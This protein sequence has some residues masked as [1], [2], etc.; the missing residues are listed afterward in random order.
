MES[1]AEK[2]ESVIPTAVLERETAACDGDRAPFKSFP[3][4]VFG[5]IGKF[6]YKTA[7]IF[8]SI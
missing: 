6:P 7:L 2:G 4:N 8:Q 5:L 3:D 1:E